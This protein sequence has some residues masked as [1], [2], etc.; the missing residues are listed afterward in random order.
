MALSWQGNVVLVLLYA[1]MWSSAM[2][3]CYVVVCDDDGAD[4]TVFDDMAIGDDM[5]V[6][7]GMTIE[8]TW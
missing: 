5:T 1:L 2:M 4:V 8:L 7:A 6:G 3:W